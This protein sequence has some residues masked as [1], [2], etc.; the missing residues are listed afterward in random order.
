MKPSAKIKRLALQG[1]LTGL[2]LILFIVEAQIPPLVPIPGVKIGLANIVTVFA[3]FFM[4]PRDGL[5]ILSGRIFLGA[6]FAGNFSSILYSGAGGLFAILTVI[7]LKIVL[8]KNQIWIAGCLGAVAHGIGQ[9]A[10]AVPLSGTSAILIYLPVLIV[11]GIITGTFTGLCAQVL[12][13]RG[14]SLWKTIF[15]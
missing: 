3:V 12:V 14:G 7:G 8:G 2:A 9:M 13:N 15:K 10:V 4:S 11:T 1:L 5:L 6:I